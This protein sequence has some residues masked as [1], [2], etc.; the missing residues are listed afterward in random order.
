LTRHHKCHAAIRAAFLTRGGS[1][2]QWSRVN[3]DPRMFNRAWRRLLGLPDATQPPPPEWRG[4]CPLTLER[5][6]DD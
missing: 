2:H 6:T 1:L 5:F 4:L 3:A